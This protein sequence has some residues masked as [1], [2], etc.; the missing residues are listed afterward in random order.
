MQK[1]PFVKGGGWEMAE[2]LGGVQGAFPESMFFGSRESMNKVRYNG[3]VSY[4]GQE[5]TW[6][7]PGGYSLPIHIIFQ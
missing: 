7:A 3:S 6:L 4:S 5:G 2:V 1:Q